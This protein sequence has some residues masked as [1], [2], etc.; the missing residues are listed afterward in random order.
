[1]NHAVVT[2]ALRGVD[3]PVNSIKDYL[4]GKFPVS[5]EQPVA[6]TNI[7]ACVQRR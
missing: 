7:P 5:V 1:M 2:A 4:S 3:N 6:S